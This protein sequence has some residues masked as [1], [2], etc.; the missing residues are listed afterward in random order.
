[1]TYLW[2]TEQGRISTQVLHEYYVT[3]TKKLKPGLERKEARVDLRDLTAW[4]PISPNTD[5][6]EAA[7][8]LEDRFSISFWDALIVA[9]AR[10]S[11][12]SALLTEDLQ[13][14]SRFDDLLV[15]DP[16]QTPVGEIPE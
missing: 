12:C 16:F 6:L 7:W 11:H 4:K 10:A 13:H 8:F 3:V 2:Q 14:G 9:A 5:M 15:V 1:M